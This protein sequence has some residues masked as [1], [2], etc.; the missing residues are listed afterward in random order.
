MSRKEDVENVA[1]GNFPL[2]KSIRH[3]QGTRFR[4]K[5]NGE[6]K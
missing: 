2:I 5:G 6:N 3:E 4:S 1:I